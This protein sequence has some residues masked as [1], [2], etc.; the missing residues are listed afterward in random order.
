MSVVVKNYLI[1]TF[2]CLYFLI[3]FAVQHTSVSLFGFEEASWPKSLV[4][5]NSRYVL[6]I[7]LIFVL[8]LLR[9]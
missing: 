6:L 2:L 9:S 3:S 5:P 1:V 4:Q 8:I 7:S